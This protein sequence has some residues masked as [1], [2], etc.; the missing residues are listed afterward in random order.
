MA[1]R[2]ELRPIQSR[3]SLQSIEFDSSFCGHRLT[4]MNTYIRIS[5]ANADENAA[6]NLAERFG[7]EELNTLSFRDA[8]TVLALWLMSRLSDA[9]SASAGLELHVL[10]TVPRGRE[11]AFEPLPDSQSARLTPVS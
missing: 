10:V 6:S 2:A 8:E 9:R 1:G 11:V 4:E 3:D 7:D 5:K